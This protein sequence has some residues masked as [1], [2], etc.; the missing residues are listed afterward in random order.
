M[1]TMPLFRAALEIDNKLGEGGFDPVTHADRNAEAAIRALITQEFPDRHLGEEFDEKSPAAS[2]GGFCWVI[3][4]IDGTRAFISGMPSWGTL[5]ALRKMASV[6]AL[7]TSLMSANGFAPCAA[8]RHCICARE[9]RRLNT[10]V[11]HAGTGNGSNYRTRTAYQPRRK[12][13]LG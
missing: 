5:I 3:D 2:G 6:Q 9:K 8:G 10:C 7:W 4:P 11:P 12:C 1:E 13:R